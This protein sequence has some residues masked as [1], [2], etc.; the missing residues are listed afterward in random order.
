MYVNYKGYPVIGRPAQGIDKIIMAMGGHTAQGIPAVSTGNKTNNVTLMGRVRLG[1]KYVFLWD[2]DNRSK[3]E[4]HRN[5][6]G[7][8]N[9]T[10]QN[11]SVQECIG[12]KSKGRVFILTRPRY[13][14]MVV[15]AKGRYRTP[16]DEVMYTLD[17]Q[18][19]DLVIRVKRCI[20][21][22]VLGITLL[23]EAVLASTALAMSASNS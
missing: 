6:T 22:V 18:L 8:F 16:S 1:N 21:C 11:C 20:S 14:M 10:C 7:I 19:G 4:T 12:P 2:R 13:A 23:A 5:M 17:K 15:K 9:F 3:L